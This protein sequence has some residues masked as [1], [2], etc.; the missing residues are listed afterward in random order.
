V[1]GT[2]GGYVVTALTAGGEVASPPLWFDADDDTVPPAT[3]TLPARRLHGTWATSGDLLLR[4]T[5]PSGNTHVDRWVVLV[6]GEPVAGN[7]RPGR[8]PSS[9]RLPARR[10]PAGDIV[11]AVVLGS[12]RDAT[13]ATAAVA[14][15][16]RVPL[17]GRAVAAGP[18]RYRLDL[19]VAP[20]WARRACGRR[21]CAG[22]RVVVRSVPSRGPA[23]AWTTT[24]TD[25]D[26]RISALVRAPRG[27]ARITVRLATA[28]RRYRVLRMGR[29]TLP[30]G[31]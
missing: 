25:G 28:E 1:P 20:S 29:L 9:V 27:S 19:A 4:W 26:G 13:S 11:V 12:T 15:G 8:V 14:V 6:D 24:W 18:G 17:T 30:V 16:A 23:G 5:N 2:S 21:V 3:V 31:G 7:D 22:V 10:V